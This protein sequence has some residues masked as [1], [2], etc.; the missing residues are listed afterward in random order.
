MDTISLE[1]DLR[2]ILL[3][4][5]KPGRYTGGEYGLRSADGDYSLSIALS[6]PDLY[7]IGMSN[8]AV[9]LLYTRCQSVAGL[10]CERI[11]A[12]APDF[13]EQLRSHDLPLFSL[14]TYRVLK[15]FDII[16]FSI[17]YELTVTNMLAILDLGGVHLHADERPDD[18]P[19]VIAGGPSVVNPVPY[20]RFVDCV[21]LGDGEMFVDHCL[22][23]LV[24][25]KRKGAGRKDL[26]ERILK[27]E[28]VWSGSLSKKNVRKYVWMDFHRET[29]PPLLPVPSIAAAHDH[30][31]VE[32]MRG[33]PH[34]CRF[35][36]A[37]GY[38]RPYRIKHPDAIIREIEHLVFTCGYR[39]IS[40]ASLSSGDYPSIDFLVNLLVKRYTHLGVSFGLPSLRIDSMALHILSDIAEVRK[41]GLTF[42]IETP[43]ESWQK[44]INKTVSLQKTIAL[45]K[46]ARTQGWKKA[47]FYFMIGLPLYSGDESDEIVDFIL[48]IKKQTRMQLHINLS[49]FV[50]KAHTPFQWARQLAEEDALRRIMAIKRRLAG[51]S[52]KVTYHS[53]FASMLEGIIARGD[54][55]IGEVIENAF[56]R[57]ARLDAWEEYLNRDLWRSVFRD[58]GWDVESEGIR[59]RGFHEKLPWESSAGGMSSTSYLKKEWRRAVR[60]ELTPSCRTQCKN[61]CGVCRDKTAVCDT[62]TETDIEKSFTL[63]MKSLVTGKERKL[64]FSF[65]K[66]GKAAY[67]SHLNCMHLFERALLRAGYHACFTS[68]YNPK[69]VISFAAPLALGIESRDEIAH[70]E[71]RNLDDAASF[72]DRMN[73]VLPEGLAVR[74]A[75]PLKNWVAGTKKVS[76]PSLYWGSDYIVRSSEG[77][78]TV[79]HLYARI[80]EVNEGSGEDSGFAPALE[81]F[82]MMNDGIC[83]RWKNIEQ[84]GINIQSFL[85]WLLGNDPHETGIHLLRHATLA[86]NNEGQPESYFNVVE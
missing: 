65:S 6:Y 76:L 44:G 30:G 50:P 56:V 46:E 41:S 28:A 40:L 43:L 84:K 85:K 52:C 36:S 11:F 71:L 64:L 66:K 54:R 29:A 8:L 47:K 73:E 37:S 31:I 70:I 42:A 20:G 57:G 4:V 81:A 14:E 67:L 78:A 27:E 60:G 49:T 32:I 17:G 2:K 62:V 34:G 9:R 58:A 24:E 39:R 74:E 1:K 12:P 51:E 13:E 19:I 63:P 53:P 75:K 86:E 77:I 83:V 21:Y 16:G 10:R 68:G 48:T 3:S 61:P 35:C 33:C 5:E 82:F 80:N 38:Y 45:L 22:K 69:P 15:R 55:R 18:E 25:L 79:I 23:E 59:K 72:I 7:E 26:L